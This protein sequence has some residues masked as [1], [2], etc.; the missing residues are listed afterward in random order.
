MPGSLGEMKSPFITR[1]SLEGERVH[2][3]RFAADLISVQKSGRPVVVLCDSNFVMAQ[4]EMFTPGVVA[5]PHWFRA[6]D[7]SPFLF[8]E[9]QY[10]GN[11]FLMLEQSWDP[12]RIRTA[13]DRQNL[14][15]GAPVL[16]DPYN[17]V[18]SYR[19]SRAKAH[20]IRTDTGER[21]EFPAS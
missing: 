17:P 21:I 10:K 14:Y 7:G 20:L 15:P 19:G 9:V 16:V 4:M 18:I 1:F 5:K 8:H 13:L 2:S 6:D 11:T 3:S 12:A